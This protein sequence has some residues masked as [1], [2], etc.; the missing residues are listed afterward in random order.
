MK[1]QSQ[2][3]FE[4]VDNSELDLSEVDKILRKL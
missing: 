3:A 2:L 4:L 1:T